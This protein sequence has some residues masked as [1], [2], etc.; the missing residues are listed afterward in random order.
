MLDVIKRLALGASRS[1]GYEILP[2]RDM[3]GRDLAIHLHQLFSALGIDCVL[4]VGANIGQYHDFLRRHVL[5][6]GLIVSFEPVARN[7]RILLEKATKNPSWKIKG[8]ALGEKRGRATINVAHETQFSSLLQPSDAPPV[9]SYAEL[10]DAARTEQI[11]VWALDDIFQ[12]LQ[13]RLGFK[14]PYLKIDTE[15]YDLKVVGG[16]ARSLR[17]VPALQTEAAVIPIYRDMP[18][19]LDTIACLNRTG[20]SVTGF[21]PI[22]RDARFRLVEFDCVMINDGWNGSAAALRHI[23]HRERKTEAHAQNFALRP[24][25]VAPRPD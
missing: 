5:F 19:Y 23:A 22:A 8:Y 1:F 3:A 12:S 4:D 17:D 20:F 10:M 7:V 18:N 21:Y 15:G 16:A 11:N 24:N 6:N 14:R 25:A 9:D 2:L 13:T